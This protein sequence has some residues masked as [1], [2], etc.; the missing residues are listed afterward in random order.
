MNFREDVAPLFE[1]LSIRGVV[2]PNRMGMAPM[3]RSC[4][5]DGHPGP[6]NVTYY[7]KRAEG[8]AG[9]ILTEAIGL[10]HPVSIGDTGLGE[11]DLPLFDGS[12]AVAAWTKVVDAVHA[13]G[14]PIIPQLWHQGV[15]RLPGSQ[16]N[17]H[18]PAF[19]PSGHYGDPEKAS[20]YYR[21][22]AQKLAVKG[23]V[24]GDAEIVEVIDSFGRAAEQAVE[25]GFDGLA[26]HGGHGYLLDQFLWD[27][28]NLRDDRWGGSRKERT[29]F[30]VEVIKRVRAAIGEDRP[31]IFRFSQ[32]KQQDFLTRL[33]DTPADL[34]EVL[35]PLADAGVDM[36]DASTRYF[37]TPAFAGSDLSLAGWAK[38][39]TGKLS[40][41]VG[42][43]GFNKGMYDTWDPVS[44]THKEGAAGF[45]N[46]EL[47]MKRFNAGE[48]DVIL[49]GRALLS[50]PAWI[51][52][53]RR[54]EP[55]APFD[56]RALDML[57]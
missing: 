54:G 11:T 44:N 18:L 41:A 37:N 43:V 36:F 17:P 12:D 22:M 20:E 26:L 47:V 4:C 31:L 16:P 3:T 24:P 21:E 2:L 57:I 40:S 13:A 15:M 39:L 33:A 49:V 5:P 1:P 19:S 53:A 34:E 28:T 29:R 23:P 48:F 51:A 30:A 46:L 45:D 25:A 7:R 10:D 27:V 8:E 56:F 55:F 6:E 52:K 9:V 50:D 14:S 42:G 35:G 38:K 32:W